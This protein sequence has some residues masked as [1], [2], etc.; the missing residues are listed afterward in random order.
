[1]FYG[2]FHSFLYHL[3]PGTTSPLLHLLHTKSPFC[4]LSLRPVSPWRLA[5]S[6]LGSLLCMG[7]GPWLPGCLESCPVTPAPALASLLWLKSDVLCFLAVSCQHE[8]GRLYGLCYPGKS[9]AAHTL[10]LPAI[11]TNIPLSSPSG[12]PESGPTS[13]QHLLQAQ[14]RVTACWVLVA[15]KH[16]APRRIPCRCVW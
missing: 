9:L 11:R 2:P 10:P 15:D 1:M 8:H 4:R 12:F 6:S 3:S 16:I 7:P 5:P 13:L 14:P